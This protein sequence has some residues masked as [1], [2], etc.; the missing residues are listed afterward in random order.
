MKLKYDR[1]WLSKWGPFRVGY[2][3]NRLYR[4]YHWRIFSVSHGEQMDLF[5]SESSAQAQADNLNEQYALAMM[6]Q[7]TAAEKLL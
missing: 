2:Q 1:D 6:A 5:S 3:Q 7:G 4:E